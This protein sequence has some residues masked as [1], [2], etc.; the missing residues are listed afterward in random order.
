[1]P[2]KEYK[3]DIEKI[4]QSLKFRLNNMIEL[5]KL[6]ILDKLMPDD[7]LPDDYQEENLKS[8]QLVLA[9][10]EI[11]NIARSFLVSILDFCKEPQFKSIVNSDQF[12][13]QIEK[14]DFQNTISVK[15]ELTEMETI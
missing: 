8:E 7:T 15:Y 1:M 10:S 4:I 3:D 11:N 2:I 6:D 9:K 13:S 14:S 5:E 12:T